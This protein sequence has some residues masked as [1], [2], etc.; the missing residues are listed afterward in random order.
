MPVFHWTK[1]VWALV[2]LHLALGELQHVIQF[3]VIHINIEY[4]QLILVFIAFFSSLST[5]TTG[6]TTATTMAAAGNNDSLAPHMRPCATR[7]CTKW[8]G[9]NLRS[10][11]I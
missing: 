5:N 11:R 6:I 7:Q 10:K 3:I 1:V 9:D 2:T 4:K 8:M